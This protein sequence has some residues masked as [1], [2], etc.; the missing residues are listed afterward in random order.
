VDTQALRHWIRDNGGLLRTY[1]QLAKNVQQTLAER[2]RADE[3]IND[4]TAEITRIENSSAAKFA[5]SNEERAWD[6]VINSNNL[7]AAARQLLKQAG[8]DPIRRRGVKAAA[9]RSVLA[10]ARR[11]D[12]SLDSN[13]YGTH[14]KS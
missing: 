1:P 8:T 2:G 11:A 6:T 3:L 5:A 4:L 14:I 9:V 7:S 10:A 13:A 12:D